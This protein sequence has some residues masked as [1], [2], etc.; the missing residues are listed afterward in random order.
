MK[1]KL[2]CAFCGKPAKFPFCY[3][4]TLDR[5]GAAKR[6]DH[7]DATCRLCVDCGHDIWDK[8]IKSQKVFIVE[9]K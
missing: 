3:E 9:T 4:L 5:I 1:K 2:V 7:P 6:K 8:M